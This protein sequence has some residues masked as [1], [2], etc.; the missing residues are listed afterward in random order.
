MTDPQADPAENGPPDRRPSRAAE[1]TSVRQDPPPTGPRHRKAVRIGCL[2]LAGLLLATVGA[3]AWFYQHLNGNLSVFD[4][5]GVAA[6]RPPAGAAS[7]GGGRPVNILLLGSDSRAGGNNE[8]GGGAVGT[9]NSDTAILLHVYADHRHAVG[10]SI[11]R[12]SLVDI[13]PC[14]LPNG[15]WT[16]PQHSQ[17]FNSAFAVGASV[18]GNPAC[19]QNT[20]EAMTGLRV[21][22]TIVVDFKGFAAMTSAVGGVEVCVPNDVNG[23]GIT[24][25]KGRQNLA[26]QQALDY[27]RARHGI[28]DGSD[29]GRMKRQQAFLAALIKK[30]QDQGFDLTT[31]LPLAD[32]ATRSLTVDQDLGTAMKL[33]TFAQSM[34]SIKLADISF[35]TAP[36]RFAGD[37][38][39]LVHPDVDTLWRLLRQDRTL[40]GQSTGQVGD[41]PSPAAAAS[42]PAGTDLTVPVVVHNGTTTDGLATRAAGELRAKGYLDVSAGSAGIARALTEVRYAPGYQGAA[43][44]LAL[45]FPGAQLQPDDT[46][47]AVEVDL[48]RDYQDASAGQSAAAG[49]SN[50]TASASASATLPGSVPSGIA[51][52]TRP[53]NAD[54]CA[55]LTYG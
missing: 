8:L 41:Q 48:G 42:P 45:F 29:I 39:A 24:L 9:G 47:G 1:E 26:G 52:N 17:M 2:S 6:S 12:D 22:H 44:Q 23:Y 46:A 16:S 31:L 15:S 13:P 38:V 53:A 51:D 21:D 10:V 14:R 27:V 18:A 28:G 49:P 34:R 19:S 55:G 7:S 3:G 43:E 35:V 30:V 33:A 5:G 4:S 50:S 37:R 32:A 36:W 20:V 11:P 40:D 25:K 54:P